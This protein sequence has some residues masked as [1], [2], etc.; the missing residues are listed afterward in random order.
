GQISRRFAEVGA[1]GGFDTVCAFTEV[2]LVRI[3]RE[4][5]AL[6]VA[7][8]DLHR[9]DGF[10]DLP[11]EADVADLEADRLPA[12]PTRELLR[13]GARPLGSRTLTGNPVANRAE[14]V[15]CRRHDDMR[16]AEA[17]VTLEFG[18]FRGD[19]RLTQ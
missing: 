15:A 8:L 9:D 1:G 12:P 4:D 5:L 3:E 19:D 18:V 10:L 2:H 13:D 17:E 11:F 16:H 6:R 14:H 7:L